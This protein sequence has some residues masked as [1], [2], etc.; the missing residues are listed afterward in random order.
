MITN[1]LFRECLGEI[2]AEA[3]RRMEITFAVA[4][5]IAELMRAKNI[6]KQDFAKKM[7]VSQDTVSKWLTGR[8]DFTLSQ[9]SKIS[10]VL[11]FP[12]INVGR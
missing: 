11:G 12:I 9:L 8:Y 3:R 5:K 4:D 1:T 7:H 6:S 2:P 10:D